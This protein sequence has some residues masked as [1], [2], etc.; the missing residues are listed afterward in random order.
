MVLKL[1]TNHQEDASLNSMFS[2]NNTANSAKWK[3][4]VNAAFRNKVSFD[5]LIPRAE[6]TKHT[7]YYNPFS[8][9]VV[10]S[11]NFFYLTGFQNGNTD[12]LIS[13]A[14]QIKFINA[15]LNSCFGQIQF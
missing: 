14:N 2:T 5:I 11:T 9:P 1:A 13:S 15:Y 8:T 6:R 4:I 7:C 12:T 3:Q 10:L